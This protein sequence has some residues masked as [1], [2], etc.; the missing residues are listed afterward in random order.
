MFAIYS[1][2]FILLQ[3]TLAF[4]MITFLFINRIKRRKKAIFNLLF[5]GTPP[6]LLK[7]N[8]Q[9]HCP[10]SELGLSRNRTTMQCKKDVITRFY[11]YPLSQSLNHV[12]LRTRVN[13]SLVNIGYCRRKKLAFLHENLVRRRKNYLPHIVSLNDLPFNATA[14]STYKPF[15]KD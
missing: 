2:A 1:L 11:N 6:Q 14:W 12:N 9:L 13:F 4:S 3:R 8:K 10:R 5:A 7:V 15:L